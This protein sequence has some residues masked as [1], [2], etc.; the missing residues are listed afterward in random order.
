MPRIP[1]IQPLKTVNSSQNIDERHILVAD[2]HNCLDEPAGED[3]SMTGYEEAI[4][5]DGTDG[6]NR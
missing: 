2:H 6:R 1:E 5:V 4:N 3:A